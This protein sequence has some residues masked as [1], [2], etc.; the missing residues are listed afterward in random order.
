LIGNYNI[1]ICYM[2]VAAAATAAAT[3]AAAA[4]A[5][6]AIQSRLI[7]RYISMIN[8]SMTLLLH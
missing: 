1:I 4:V 3:A 5:A 7:D 8:S 6:A 2:S